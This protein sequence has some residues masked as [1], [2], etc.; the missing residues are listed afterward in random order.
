MRNFSNIRHLRY[1]MLL[2]TL[3]S[4]Q[5]F[6]Q[7]KWKDYK[8]SVKGDTINRVDRKGLRQGPWVVRQ[9]A[10]R[11]ER[12]YEEEGFYA[13][14]QKTGPWRRYTLEG[15]LE[16]LEN[17]RFGMKNGKC[18]Y[19]NLAGHPI[20]EESWRAIDPQNPY[21]TVQ[22][23]DINDPT[24]VTGTKII[25][26][27]PTARKHGT[28][29]YYDERTGRFAAKEEWIND[30][31]KSD[32]AKGPDEGLEPIMPAASEGT[33]SKSVK[34]AL[35]ATRPAYEKKEKVTKPAAVQAFE[36]KHS[37]KKKYDVRDGATGG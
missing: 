11:S 3:L 27:E 32:L 20:R 36:K 21:D 16:A 9:E 19:F 4:L 25:K 29:T 6:A 33:A 28:W 37:G 22:I 34:E 18:V 35:D 24:R 30:K 31:R 15:D 5:S 23:F 26:V 8:I 17:F 7:G 12:G 1:W 10:V 2:L 14:D 13:D